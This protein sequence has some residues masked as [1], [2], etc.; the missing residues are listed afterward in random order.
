MLTTVETDTFPRTSCWA[1][2][3]RLIPEILQTSAVLAS[4]ATPCSQ[5]W[6]ALAGRVIR[7]SL[8]NGWCVDFSCQFAAGFTRAP[9]STMLD[10]RARWSVHPPSPDQRVLLCPPALAPF[11]LRISKPRAHCNGEDRLRT[12]R[13]KDGSMTATLVAKDVSGG[14]DH[15]QLF[16]RLSLTVAPGDVVGVVGA[17]G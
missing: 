13:R 2:V 17:N 3:V 11:L 9:V 5:R 6:N 14:H 15:R 10:G 1:S 7:G 4:G 8:Q 16:S 12:L